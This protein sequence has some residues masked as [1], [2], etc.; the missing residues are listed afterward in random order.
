PPD[1]KADCFR[2]LR[3]DK[4]NGLEL[5]RAIDRVNQSRWDDAHPL[6]GAHMCKQSHHGIRLEC[7]QPAAAILLKNFID[8]AAALDI[9]GQKTERQLAHIVPS[10]LLK[11]RKW[12]PRTDKQ[13]VLLFIKLDRAHACYWF[14][15]DVRDPDFNLQVFQSCENF[16]GGRGEDRKP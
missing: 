11:V 3:R 2:D 12:A 16:G 1:Q 5:T 7:R 15:V 14:V 4:R 13:H 9:G 10:Y 6:T 8:D